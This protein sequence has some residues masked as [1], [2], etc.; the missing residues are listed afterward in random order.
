MIYDHIIIGGGI[1]GLYFAFKAINKDPK[2]KI[3]L[4]EST[5]RLGGR[6]YTKSVVIN[7]SQTIY[8]SGASRILPTH[9]RVIDLVKELG[10]SDKLQIE[11]KAEIIQYISNTKKD[12]LNVSHELNVIMCKIN[13]LIRN[14]K[15][16]S[17]V[18]S[19]N[20]YDFVKKYIDLNTANKLSVMYPYYDEIID[21]NVYNA[22]KCMINKNSDTI[23]R[24]DGGMSQLIYGLHNN[25][26]DVID[27]KLKSKV[28]FINLN[29]NEI[30]DIGTCLGDR[31][32]TKNVIIACPKD[33]I[34]KIHINK[35]SPT[36]Q[37]YLLNLLDSVSSIPFVRIYAIFPLDNQKKC[38]FSDLN[39]FT[40]SN[41]IRFVTP[42]DKSKGL[43]QICY[44]GTINAKIMK[45]IRDRGELNEYLLSYFRSLFP[46]KIIPDMERI[47][48]EYH[49]SAIHQWDLNK[50]G[51]K[52]SEQ[53]L[54]PFASHNMFI[55]GEAYSTN[56]EWS[57]GAIE[58]A[59][60][61]INIIY[62]KRILN[63]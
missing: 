39:A 7:E 35:I 48:F 33:A 55:I 2:S 14:D 19:M 23:Y 52:I 46:D 42:Y 29:K 50:I 62:S 36:E 49:D 63:I 20:L 15:V 13:S 1:S 11:Q 51:D 24:L 17:D 26:K 41:P 18:I 56:Q 59:Q 12:T 54:K 27:I 6:N 16:I 30:Y 60:N 44:T 28:E 38:W 57:E 31:Y 47:M 58:T 45:A 4:L 9:T 37:F 40:T 21:T 5:D 32:Q 61:A 25:V 10:L 34:K 43:I 22:L 8:E 3:L 53:I